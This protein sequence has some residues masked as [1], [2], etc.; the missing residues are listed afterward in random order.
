VAIQLDSDSPSDAR[1]H[2]RRQ[3]W[4]ARGLFGLVSVGH[5]ILRSGNDLVSDWF[6]VPDVASQK[7]DMNWPNFSVERMAADG[8]RFQIRAIVLRR[9]R[10]PRRYV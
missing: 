1:R 9:H 6:C 2:C 10:S 8:T 7:N 4:L 3:V 5:Y